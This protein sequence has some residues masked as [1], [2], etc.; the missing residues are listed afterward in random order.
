MKFFI[1][2]E[3]KFG[4]LIGLVLFELGEVSTTEVVVPL[5]AKQLVRDRA[6]LADLGLGG[7][8]IGSTLVAVLVELLYS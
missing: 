2:G 8:G 5:A 7:L 6:M 3:E 4:V 1:A